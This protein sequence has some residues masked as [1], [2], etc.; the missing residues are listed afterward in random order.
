MTVNQSEQLQQAIDCTVEEAVSSIAL[1][2]NTYKEGK[3]Y[4]S[5]GVDLISRGVEAI[6]QAQL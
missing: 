1:L 6:Y 4:P 2:C 3:Q 5:K